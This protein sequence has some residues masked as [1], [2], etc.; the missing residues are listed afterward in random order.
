[1]P[2]ELG[3][4][5]RCLAF[6][7]SSVN[8]W[9]F[10][11]HSFSYLFC[12]CAFLFPTH[13]HRPRCCSH[14]THGRIFP[15]MQKGKLSLRC[16]YWHCWKFPSSREGSM[17]RLKSVSSAVYDSRWC[18]EERGL[19]LK[20]QKRKRIWKPAYTP[21]KH[22]VPTVHLWDLLSLLELCKSDFTF[23]ELASCGRRQ[24]SPCP[25]RA[26]HCHPLLTTLSVTEQGRTPGQG[27]PAATA[28][29]GSGITS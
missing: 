8:R 16:Y 4:P 1:M 10:L 12:H 13:S 5:C 22:R 6:S 14:C 26:Y 21:V 25:G 11:L 24:E 20:E 29:W 23:L 3:G 18:G 15:R 9:T 27:P 7:W 19:G 2:D 17:Q 28:E